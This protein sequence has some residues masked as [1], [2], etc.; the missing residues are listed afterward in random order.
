MAGTSDGLEYR[1]ALTRL[2]RDPMNWSRADFTA[3]RAL[4]HRGRALRT[5]DL[6]NAESQAS[7][8]DIADELEAAIDTYVRS[9]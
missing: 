3:A 5:S 8:D 9:R 6:R 7:L 2:L 1:A 4:A